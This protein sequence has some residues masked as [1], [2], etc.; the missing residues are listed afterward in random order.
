LFGFVEELDCG[1]A[2]WRDTLI[3][4]AARR[5]PTIEDVHSWVTSWS[6]AE[7]ATRTREC[8]ETPTHYKWLLY[9]GRRQPITVWWHEYKSEKL[10]GAGYTQLPH[11]HRYDFCSLMLR[12]SFV[13]DGF[14]AGTPLV[15]LDESKL[16]AGDW[17]SM[18]SAQIHALRDIADGTDTLV[19]QGPARRGFSRVY[20]RDGSYRVLPDFMAKWA[21]IPRSSAVASQEDRHALA[22]CQ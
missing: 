4:I 22:V 13:S 20:E 15:L 18:S 17:L 19:F 12:G 9:R 6:E 21:E 8:H 11:D 7:A 2:D 14:A 5:P 10:R 3:D 1:R 16:L